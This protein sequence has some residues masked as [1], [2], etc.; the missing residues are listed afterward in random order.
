M[1]ELLNLK[2]N[3]TVLEKGKSS[4]I[5]KWMQYEEPQNILRQHGINKEIFEEYANNVFDYFM[6]VINEILELGACPVIEDLLRYL[7]DRNVTAKELFIICSHFKLSM[8]EYTYDVEINSKD[9][10]KAI[11][12]VFDRNFSKVLEIYSQTI[13]EK[14][15]EIGKNV[16][17][18]NLEIQ[19]VINH[20]IEMAKDATIWYEIGSAFAL[21]AALAAALLM[22][23][24]HA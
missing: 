3:I 9:L 21:A 19:A 23:F 16:E 11:T 12:Y 7:K 10:F 24:I 14:D 4:V 5:Q 17:A 8:V 15:I 6:G 2:S 22:P 18:G 20:Q 13:Y 1:N